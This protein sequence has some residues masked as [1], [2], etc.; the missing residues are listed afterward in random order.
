MHL[1]FHAEVQPCT[2]S[3]ALLTVCSFAALGLTAPRSFRIQSLLHQLCTC[4]CVQQPDAKV[5]C[6]CTTGGAKCA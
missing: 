4:F 1:A 3:A 5:L 6:L 2:A